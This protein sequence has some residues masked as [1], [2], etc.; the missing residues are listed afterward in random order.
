[1]TIT[2][3]TPQERLRAAEAAAYNIQAVAEALDIAVETAHRDGADALG[4]LLGILN[5]RLRHDVEAILAAV[6]RER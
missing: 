6:A 5:E 2:P 4:F 1:M 3:Q